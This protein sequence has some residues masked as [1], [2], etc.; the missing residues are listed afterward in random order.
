MR[1]LVTRPEEDAKPLAAL[2]RARG[3]EVILEP[4]LRIEAAADAAAPLDLGGVQALLFTSANGVRAFARRAPECGLPVFAVGEA[5]AGAA[6][7]AGFTQA[8][9]AAG[10]VEDLA[11]LVA[12]RLKPGGGALYHGAGQHLAGDLKARLEDVGFTLRREVLYH[13]QAPEA[14]SGA[15]R[16]ALLEG[17]IDA[18]AFFSPRTAKTFVK[19]IQ[20]AELSVACKALDALCL[21]AAVARSLRVLAWRDVH[22][23]ARPSQDALL[24]CIDDLAGR[25]GAQHAEGKMS[26]PDGPDHKNATPGKDGAAETEPAAHQVIALFGGIRPMAS[27]LEVA[28]STVQGWRERASI[29]AS[30]HGQI[31]AT[32]KAH[33]I[34][35]DPKT[36]AASDQA[37]EEAG[38]TAPASRIPT[39]G[40]KSPGTDK[41]PAP[42]VEKASAARGGSWTGAFL[43]AAVVFA[44]GAGTAV[45]TRDAWMPRFA[46][47][48]ADNPNTARI[49][50]LENRIAALKTTF[51]EDPNAT[52]M[53]ALEARLSEIAAAPGENPNTGRIEALENSLESLAEVARAGGDTRQLEAALAANE[54][55]AQDT[56]RGLADLRRQVEALAEARAVAG[57][58]TQGTAMT[59]AVLQMR[60]ALRAA[61]P[62]EAA[63]TTL[64]ALAAKAPNAAAMTQAI[65]PLRPFA[66]QGAPSLESLQASFPA[67][68]RAAIAQSRG[69]E[70]TGLLAKA[71]R[72]LSGLVS[73]RPLGPV[74]GDSA[75]AI[76]ARAEA[77]AEA[78]DLASA[79]GEL[80]A[81]SG[82]AA[83]AAAAWRAEAQDRLTAQT[84]LKR[85]GALL[86]AG[87]S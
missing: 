55:R 62:F 15:T 3:H 81:L 65:A 73:V 31:Q 39:S 16:T 59:L 10:D 4:L 21:S 40:S 19:L 23:A 2:L 69:G 24:A 33:K 79:L 58:S 53:A 13:A 68:A 64:E 11:R 29:P 71:W 83:E 20:Q 50:A 18:A 60:D 57:V 72:R 47:A 84:A 54:A 52:R 70:D 9:S 43:I 8:V 28:V 48:P 86:A 74:E 46:A 87:Q 66:A 26:A 82:P 30:R 42:K 27:K 1:V 76:V 78:A 80:D 41:T 32:A 67:V 22:T 44:L 51:D 38:E 49:A 25:R 12:A 56:G 6:R 75:E 14:L 17:K 35:L 45:M 63:L 5:S 77:H 7:E 85:L 34:V 61:E 36:L 37:P